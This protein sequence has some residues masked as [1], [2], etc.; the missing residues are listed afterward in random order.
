MIAATDIAVLGLGLIGIGRNPTTSGA[1]E[2]GSRKAVR[3]NPEDPLPQQA[4]AVALHQR[5][6]VKGAFKEFREA[7][8]FKGDCWA[9][10]ANLGAALAREGNFEEGIAELR[11]ALRLIPDMADTHF[12][13]GQTLERKGDKAGGS[14]AENA[15]ALQCTSSGR[16]PVS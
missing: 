12:P 1:A 13:L 5:G 11:E 15:L 2:N 9:A 8:R 4:L 3:K 6:D 14:L 10:H 7:V 16:Q